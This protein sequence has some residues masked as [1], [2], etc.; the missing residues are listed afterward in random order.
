LALLRSL[1]PQQWPTWLQ[2]SATTILLILAWEAASEFGLIPARILAA[3]TAVAGTAWTLIASGT[4]ESNLLVS[5]A[6]VLVGLSIALIIGTTL[7]LTAGLSRAGELAIDAPMQM[8][9]TMPF[10]ALVPLFILWFGIGEPPKIALVALGGTFPIYLTLFA[11][12]RGVDKRLVEAGDC[13]GMTKAALIRHVIL[14]GALPS[15]LV[16][17]RYAIGVSWLSLVVAEQVNATAGIG[18]L[19][20]DARDYM[21]T[22]IIVVCLMVYSLL[23][24]GT[25]FIVRTLEQ[26]ALAWRPALLNMA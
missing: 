14:P 13:F 11:G 3:P 5:L 26:K 8:L 15:F 17:L 1:I 18:Y 16:G 9:R 7:A 2:R 4:L 19:I 22:D 10:L 23:G 24:L 20:D 25:D 12:I 21:R 6:R